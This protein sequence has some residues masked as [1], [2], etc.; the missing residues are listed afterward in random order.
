PSL[1]TPPATFAHEMVQLAARQEV[2][3]HE[4]FPRAARALLSTLHQ[5]DF[6]DTLVAGRLASAL[7]RPTEAFAW[8]S[9]GY[10]VARVRADL[11]QQR[12]ALRRAVRTLEEIPSGTV[13]DVRRRL[14]VGVEYA[15]AEMQAGSQRRSLA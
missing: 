4:G 2:A 7:S 13:D 3:T 5:D 8:F 12:A 10:E 15:W 14:A 11:T 1:A 9:R 6:D